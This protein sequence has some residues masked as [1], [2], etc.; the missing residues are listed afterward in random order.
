M[1]DIGQR[2]PKP[3]DR[4]IALAI[5]NASFTWHK[6]DA[7]KIVQESDKKLVKYDR[8]KTVLAS[9]RKSKP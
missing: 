5:S 1:D 2:F 3:L 9:E 7:T 4:S 6:T 8:E